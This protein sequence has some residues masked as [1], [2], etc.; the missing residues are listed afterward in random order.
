MTHIFPISVFGISH[1][2]AS[3]EIREQIALSADDQKYILNAIYHENNRID[4]VLILSTCNRVEVYISGIITDTILRSIRQWLSEYKKCPYFAEDNLVY[5][6]R[7]YD[8][9]NHFFK[10]I[11]GLDSQITGET[12]ITHQVKTAFNQA[13]NCRVT[14]TII[15]KM[16]EFALNAQKKVRNNT[17]LSDG[18]VSISL[19]GVD[20]AR[21]VYSD[22]EDKNV[23]LIGAGE[24]A[25]LTAVNFYDRNIQHINVLNRTVEKAEALA[26]H[27][28]GK[29]YGFSQLLEAV[30][31]ADII[32]TATSSQNYVLTF[33]MIAPVCKSRNFRP[34]LLIDL[35]LPR[36][37]DPEIEN[38][39]GAYLYNLD[40]LNSIV[41]SNLERRTREIPKANKIIADSI[42]EFEKWI[43]SHSMASV[44][45]RL[46][47]H[48]DQI[49]I[50]EINRLKKRLPDNSLDEIS[51]LTQ[52]IVNK[53]MHQHIKTLKKKTSNPDQYKDHVKMFYELYE[54]DKE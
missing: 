12:Q 14:D 20:L 15:N 5:Q 44:I 26:S 36:N 24:T 51:Y 3:V 13:F 47:E 49:R 30:A 53:I 43:N 45:G 34:L 18:P 40:H 41:N 42:A 19:A 23:L 22:I 16:F 11:S 21:K 54:I 6:Y 48:F 27:Y 50:A 7:G 39:D 37:I 4:G 17:Y 33:D 46:K 32:I 31:L 28:G 29:A 1:N 8:A 2:T 25:E 52:S 9:V 35:S 38:L 10:V